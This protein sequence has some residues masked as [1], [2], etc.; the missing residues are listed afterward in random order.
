MNCQSGTPEGR[1]I[2]SNAIRMASVLFTMSFKEEWSG[3]RIS[4]ARKG[5]KAGNWYNPD[6]ITGSSFAYGRRKKK[7]RRGFKGIS[8]PSN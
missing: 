5:R 7:A 8:A 4:F 6:T 1:R 3:W 2:R